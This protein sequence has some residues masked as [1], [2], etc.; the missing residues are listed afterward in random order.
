MTCHK[1]LCVADLHTAAVLRM[2][3]DSTPDD[4]LDTMVTTFSPTRAIWPDVHTA[5]SPYTRAGAAFVI[6]EIL[7]VERRDD[8][9]FGEVRWVSASPPLL[10]HGLSVAFTRDAD[11]GTGAKR[12]WRLLY[13]YPRSE[14]EPVQRTEA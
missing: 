13:G 2:L 10:A 3:G 6:G 8:A 5:E 14:P 1:L 9:L 7:A 11:T 4:V 12:G